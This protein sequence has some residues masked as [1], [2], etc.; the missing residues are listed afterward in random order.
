LAEVE[1]AH[2]LTGEALRFTVP[3]A[4]DME[5]GLKYLRR[6]AAASPEV[7]LQKRDNRRHSSAKL[8]GRRPSMKTRARR[9]KRPPTFLWQDCSS[10][11]QWDCCALPAPTLIR[12][13]ALAEH[14]AAQRAQAVADDVLSHLWPRLVS[15][16][17]LA[18]ARMFQVDDDGAMVYPP[19]YAAVPDP[20]PLDPDRLDAAQQALWRDALTSDN[21]PDARQK[22]LR[23]FL[24]TDPPA[25]FAALA[26]Y[27]RGLRL[28]KAGDR[29]AS[30]E[31]FRTVLT[32]YPNATAESGLVLGPLAQ[33]KLFETLPSARGP[34]RMLE[35]ENLCS[36]LVHSP[37]PITPVLLERICDAVAD[38]Q[39]SSGLELTNAPS[40]C[41][42]SDSRGN[43]RGQLSRAG[44]R[45][46]KNTSSCESGSRC[47]GS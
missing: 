29:T 17:V 26:Q 42:R 21:D 16:E 24:Q 32:Q 25:E 35:I 46:G 20:Q 10:F 15:S 1:F 8:S 7:T 13:R 31:A 33:V 41:A 27:T 5:V 37:G 18:T 38:G 3:P 6:F 47:N 23:S 45:P 4:H 19:P 9:N 22:A 28:F 2:P 39:P 14:E 34:A 12:D 40:L 43:L 30:G 44:L 36:N 11:C